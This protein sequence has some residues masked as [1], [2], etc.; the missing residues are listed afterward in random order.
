[1]DVDGL[2]SRCAER[3]GAIEEA[4]LTEGELNTMFNVFRR[5]V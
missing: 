4:L 5:E 3:G 2:L 1:L